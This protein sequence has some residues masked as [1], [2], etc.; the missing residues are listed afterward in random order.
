MVELNS[1]G[2]TKLKA[3]SRNSGLPIYS[4]AE[5]NVTFVGINLNDIKLT[6]DSSVQKYTIEMNDAF[7]PDL[8]SYRFYRTPLLGWYICATNDVVDPFDPDTGLYS[9][10]QIVIPSLDK[11]F[12]QVI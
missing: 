4:D 1:I 11:I 6:P 2:T 3:Y 8:I 7:R 10:R 5:N 12:Q 9:G